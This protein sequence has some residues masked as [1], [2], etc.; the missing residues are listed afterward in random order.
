[1]QLLIPSTESPRS[2][3]LDYGPDHVIRAPRYPRRMV[4]IGQGASSS[5]RSRRASIVSEPA[6]R[7]RRIQP[8]RRRLTGSPRFAAES[9]KLS[10]SERGRRC[11]SANSTASRQPIGCQT[12][13][14]ALASTGTAVSLGQQTAATDDRRSMG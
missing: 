11:G 14:A 7:R 8:V 10:G 1:M 6:T 2:A 13:Q 5:V 3:A 9:D 4:K 12:H